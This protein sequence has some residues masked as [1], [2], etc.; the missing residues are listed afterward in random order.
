VKETP[1]RETAVNKTEM[2]AF[3]LIR[4]PWVSAI[5]R[6]SPLAANKPA[7][8]ADIGVPQA[9]PTA[10]K[11]VKKPKPKPQPLSQLQ[12]P[13]QGF[14]TLLNPRKNFQKF[15]LWWEKKNQYFQNL[16][17]YAQL[18]DAYSYGQVPVI[19]RPPVN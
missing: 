8:N 14:Q 11:T 17:A 7:T 6:L 4:L 13:K 12:K 16:M 15:L 19:R 1:D 3:C 18:R 5:Y 2:T 10:R 9:D